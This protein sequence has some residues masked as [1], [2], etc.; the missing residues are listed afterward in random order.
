VRL[1]GTVVSH[2]VL[3]PDWR[4][5]THAQSE[6]G[7]ASCELHHRGERSNHG[8]AATHAA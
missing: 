8:E 3:Q 5:E 1:T 4:W 2:H 6:V 7:T